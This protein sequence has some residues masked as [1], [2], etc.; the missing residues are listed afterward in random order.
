ME[1]ATNRQVSRRA[2]TQNGILYMLA[3]A[4]VAADRAGALSAFAGKP[5]LKIGYITDV[6]YADTADRDARNYRAS[7]PKMEEAVDQLNR[8][9][10]SFVVH[11]GDLID[12]LPAPT[13]ESERA[14]LKRIDQE[15]ARITTDR[16]YVLGNHC[17]F[18]MTKPEY[19]EMIGKPKSYY[20]FDKGKFHFIVLDA[21]Y[22]KDG[23]DYGRR[24]FEWTDTE[25]PASER[26]W[27]QAD[28]KATRHPTIV[29]AHQRLDKPVGDE[30]G[31]HSSPEVREILERSGKVHAVFMGHSHVN[32]YRTINGIHYCTLDAVIGGN[33][34]D[35]NA[36]SVIEIYRDGSLKL[37]G[38]CKHSANPL[39]RETN[40]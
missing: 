20:S 1:H 36:Y 3:G 18:S 38:F 25:I 40:R 8:Y 13:P 39:T 33:G 22:R 30:E 35:N 7:L 28:L 12:A 21:C 34:A 29:F 32:D 11:G 6:H 5:D 17:I 23:V 37:D 4:M 26:E 27:L 15:F 14:F 31:V 10:L 24:N 9:G 16:H 19:L 2:F